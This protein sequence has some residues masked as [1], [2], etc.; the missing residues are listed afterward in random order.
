MTKENVLEIQE[1]VVV[2]E[3]PEVVEELTEEE[4]RIQQLLMQERDMHK[5][6]TK[7]KVV[8]IVVTTLCYLFLAAVAIM[9]LFP[10]YWMIISSLKTFDEYK[11]PTPTFFP[12]ERDWANFAEAFDKGNL[13]M[14][15]IN[16]V[17]V[18]I[19]STILSLVLTV[20][21]A[22]AFARLE[23]KGKNLLFAA[24]LA[25]MMIPGE[26]FTITNYQTVSRL[27]WLDTYSVMI[28]PFL[29]S[30]FYVYLLRQNFLQIPNELYL[31][32]KVDGTSDLKYLWKVM[33]PL[34]LPTLISITIL[35]LMGSWNSYMW[36]NLVTDGNLH[37]LVTNGL[38]NAFQVA[39]EGV[40]DIDYPVQM[41]AVAIVSA[42]LLVLFMCFRKYI[43]KG[44]SRSG[45]KG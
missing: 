29:V 1:E 23:F 26:L 15:F 16:T 12:L 35:K 6:T 33:I 7:Q 24:L 2:N 32:A 44:V 25:T 8:K 14:L 19:V 18:G 22:F 42:P 43:M 27:N 10:F 9:I 40:T 21:S 13:G 3:E 38:R 45:I 5:V 11:L 4:K 37:K 17:F 30:V 20:L 36:P 31:A 39:G 28:I 34:S 41:A